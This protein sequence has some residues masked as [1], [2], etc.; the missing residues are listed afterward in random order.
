MILILI[1]IS[2]PKA[3]CPGV[4]FVTECA[5][6]LTT[7]AMDL[8][9]DLSFS[10]LSLNWISSIPHLSLIVRWTRSITE[11]T[12]GFF[13]VVDFG[14][15]SKLCNISWNSAHKNSFMLS[16]I[17]HSGLWYRHNHS[18]SNSF[19][20][21]T[22]FLLSFG[23]ISNRNV[24]TS[25]IVR[26]FSW[27][28]ITLKFVCLISTFHGPIRS[29]CKV[30][31]GL[32]ATS[33]LKGSF[34]YFCFL[35]FLTL[36]TCADKIFNIT[37][38]SLPRVVHWHC[39]IHSLLPRMTEILMEPLHQLMWQWIWHYLLETDG[40]NG[41]F[42]IHSSIQETIFTTCM[43]VSFSLHS[44]FSVLFKMFTSFSCLSTVGNLDNASATTLNSP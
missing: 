38:H 26:A 13:T 5:V 24:P 10:F 34:A 21:D 30:W 22:A 44:F 4:Y 43:L 31:N 17:T 3:S 29:T 33:S 42:H 9:M 15:M 19:A 8:K 35:Q 1:N 11:F 27:M 25:I 32:G 37:L 20:I 23:T 12:C 14:L 41:L 16:W 40:T 28:F 39:T 6:D 18:W 36:H 7:Q 2:T